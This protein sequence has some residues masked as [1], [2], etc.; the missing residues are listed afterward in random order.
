MG[1]STF[2]SARQMMARATKQGTSTGMNTGQQKMMLYMMPAMLIVFGFIAHFPLGVLIYMLTS[3]LWTF[4][5]QHFVIGAM[6]RREAA[7]PKADGGSGGGTGGVGARPRG[8]KSP[9][10]DTA[11]ITTPPTIGGQ[12][13]GLRPGEAGRT[14]K[15]PP[16]SPKGGPS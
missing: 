2:F 9:S 3:N 11:S 8:P 14:R 16:T 5:Q 15:R 12:V 1:A 10:G 4:G 7:S 6:D 13:P